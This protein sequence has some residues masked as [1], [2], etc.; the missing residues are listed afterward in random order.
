MTGVGIEMRIILFG[1]D[2]IKVHAER[3]R[4]GLVGNRLRGFARDYLRTYLMGLARCRLVVPDGQ[5]VVT[6]APVRDGDIRCSVRHRVVVTVGGGWP[7][8]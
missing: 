1:P 7:V 8:G 4:V 3:V 6:I 5:W 2:K